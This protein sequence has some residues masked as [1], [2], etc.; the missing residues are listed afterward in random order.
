MLESFG[1]FDATKFSTDVSTRNM[2]QG[3]K[4]PVTAD[5]IVKRLI[6]NQG[7]VRMGIYIEEHKRLQDVRENLKVV[8]SATT[9]PKSSSLRLTYSKRT[10]ERGIGADAAGG[11]PQGGINEYLNV[12]MERQN[13][14]LEGERW[15]TLHKY[16]DSDLVLLAAKGPRQ[17]AR[18]QSRNAAAA[19]GLSGAYEYT[20]NKPEAGAVQ[21]TSSPLETA[22]QKSP[23]SSFG[24]AA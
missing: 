8:G 22:L 23:T 20:G 18:S 9:T 14:H 19:S 5:E 21:S 17:N 4:A 16:K 24:A 6:A 13:N 7:A 1:R 15:Q 10:R 2:Q 12:D 3:K 11:T